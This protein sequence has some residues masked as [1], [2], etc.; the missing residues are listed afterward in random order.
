MRKVP[1][2]AYEALVAEG[3]G[4]NH[5]L[6]KHCF[7]QLFNACKVFREAGTNAGG[8]GR[9]SSKGRDKEVPGGGGQVKCQTGHHQLQK[10]SCQRV[11]KESTGAK[12]EVSHSS[13]RRK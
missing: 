8:R 10:Q 6:F 13:R 12:S 3:V 9:G 2:A 11:F 5:R 1:N 7:R 4:E